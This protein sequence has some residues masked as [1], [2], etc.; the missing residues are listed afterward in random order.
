M[1]DYMRTLL[2]FIF[3]VVG[4]NAVSF[5]VMADGGLSHEAINYRDRLN[6]LFPKA[7]ISFVKG[8][9]LA[10]D[11]VVIDRLS[12]IEAALNAALNN[13]EVSPPLQPGEASDIAKCCAVVCDGGCGSMRAPS[14]QGIDTF[15]S[16]FGPAMGSGLLNQ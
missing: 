5:S 15:D 8:A 2:A 4:L 11:Q 13:N 6:K 7:K 1:G 9:E 12:R 14:F 16:T 10:S 3:V